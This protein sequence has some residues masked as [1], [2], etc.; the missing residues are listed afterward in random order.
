MSGRSLSVAY[1]EWVVMN[2]DVPISVQDEYALM[3]IDAIPMQFDVDHKLND[4]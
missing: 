3:L 1:L 2:C 4:L